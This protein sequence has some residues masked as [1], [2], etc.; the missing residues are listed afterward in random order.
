MTLYRRKDSPYYWVKFSAIKGEVRAF[1]RST[2]TS[3][4]RLAQQ[5]HDKLQHERWAQDRLGVKPARTWDD[6]SAKWM[7]ETAHKR[8]HQWDASM[9]RWFQPNLAASPWLTSAGKFLIR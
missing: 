6:A 9:L 2:G 5:Y 7:E 8:T 3:E 1:V 4:K